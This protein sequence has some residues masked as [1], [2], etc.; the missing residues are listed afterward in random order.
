MEALTRVEVDGGRVEDAAACAALAETTAAGLG[1]PLA[2]ALAQRARARVLLADGQGADA[3]RL[4]LTSAAAAD[5]AGAPVEAARSRVLAGRALV[6]AGDR[7]QAVELLRAAERELDERGAL[8][9]RAD[10]R[11]ELRRLGARSRAA[12]PVRRATAAGSTRS[13]GASARWRS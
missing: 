12:R 8:R 6:A 11:R 1:L 10:A 5:G 2:D 3:A 4:A 13:H 9:D 7:A